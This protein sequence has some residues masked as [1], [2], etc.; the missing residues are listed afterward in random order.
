MLF[1]QHA[2]TISDHGPFH[3]SVDRRETL[4][5]DEADVLMFRKDWLFKWINRFRN[6]LLQ[7]TDIKTAYDANEQYPEWVP[8]LTL[9][10]PATPAHE[11]KMPEHGIHTVEFDRI[12]VWTGD[13][14]GMEFRLERPDLDELAVG[15]GDVLASGAEAVNSLLHISE[16]P[17]S[18]YK[19]S[20]YSVE[21]W[22]SA[23]LIHLHDGAATS[24]DECK[25]PIKTPD[26]VLNRN[27]VH[28]AAA[29]LAGARG[30]LKGVSDEQKAQAAQ[31]LVRYYNQLD[32]EPPESLMQLSDFIVDMLTH[33]AAVKKGAGAVARVAG[34]VSFAK[35][36]ED[37]RAS[38]AIIAK[39]NK[40]YNSKD[41]AKINAK[42][43]YQA[44]KKLKTRLRNPKDPLVKQYRQEH[45]EAYIKRLEE[46]ANSMSNA[47]GTAADAFDGTTMVKFLLDEDGFIVG[48]KENTTAADQINKSAQ[49]GEI[50]VD[51]LMH[52]GIKGMRWGQRKEE[53]TAVA[54][55]AT[56][57]VP[58]GTKR[59][60]QVAVTGGENHPASPDAIR[61]AQARA[62]LVK[63]GPAALSNQELRDVATRIQLE[64]QV[65]QMTKPAAQKFITR[66][67]GQQG[68]QLATQAAQKQIRK[69][70]AKRAATAALI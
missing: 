25:L 6:Q 51:G 35:R 65:S 38:D 10:Y 58:Q 31:A 69:G 16:K 66:F 40:S 30:G 23:C 20:D 52:Y 37:G 55:K 3:M 50:F 18:D 54:P 64:Q 13:F 15:W 45:R 4:G 67:L 42:P 34:D 2:V 44:A 49:H 1:V 14:V 33:G 19:A 12:A 53:P 36:A 11:D 32:E 5:P 7:N 41:V 17:W 48:L 68:N 62:K 24:K 43:E 9:G 29:A 70:L 61:V 21:Q 26:G 59:K 28:A 8:H 56:S 22:H 46:A 47:S 60:T 39:A 57:V 27:G 63:S